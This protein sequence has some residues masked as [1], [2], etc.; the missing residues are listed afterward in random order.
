[1]KFGS[2]PAR[3]MFPILLEMPSLDSSDEI[4]QIFNDTSVDIP[5]WMFLSWI[6]QILSVLSFE[7]ASFVDDLIIRMA[8]T[9]PLAISYPFRLS[10]DHFYQSH[11]MDSARPLVRELLQL[12]H[13]PTT[14]AFVSAMLNLCV[15]E[16]KLAH[17]L[18]ELF[19]ELSTI[20]DASVFKQRLRV[21]MGCV[22]PDGHETL[23]GRAFD[24]IEKYRSRI[25]ALEED[26]GKYKSELIK[27]IKSTNIYNISAFAKIERTIQNILSSLDAD[28]RLKVHKNDSLRTLSP[29]LLRFQ[30][31]GRDSSHLE[32]PGQ[33]KGD[34]RPNSEQHV[35]IVKFGESVEIF[36]TLRY[37]IRV[38]L[39][40]SDGHSYNFLIK[41]GEDLRQDQRVQQM[42][43]LMSE[44]LRD[45]AHC[46]AHSL[47]LQTY[48]VVPLSVNCGMLGW[49]ED[50]PPM[51]KVVEK[52]MERR[53]VPL[54]RLQDFRHKHA[55]FIKKA[56]GSNVASQFKHHLHYY[57]KA[58]STYSRMQVVLVFFA[59]SS[60]FLDYFMYSLS[61]PFAKL[62]TSFLP[63]SSGERF[64]IWPPLHNRSLRCAIILP[65]AK[66][67]C[68]LLIGCLALVI[69]IYPMFCLMSG[70]E[71]SL[72]LISVWL[73]GLEPEIRTCQ[74][75]FRFV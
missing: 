57:G 2:Q 23:N 34:R 36:E 51:M 32:L 46:R 70:L 49:V 52:W 63:S 56:S 15:P 73:S 33:Y 43:T 13:N 74:S 21:M 60:L 65:Q 75:F 68:P 11:A 3:Q 62:N 28:I 72:A 31:C 71:G 66:P 18:H 35:L 16:K 20:T 44:Q 67:H 54:S 4:K 69:A 58:A 8:R 42:L 39:H 19:Y 40:G 47:S 55:T 30:W 22:W 14:D 53:Q 12:L 45:D 41:Y 64:T 6:P 26:E 50:S 37:P 1:M 48:A 24:R 17:H 10:C 5:D 27:E 61:T 9:Y 29:W 59:P 25:A 7:K 38:A